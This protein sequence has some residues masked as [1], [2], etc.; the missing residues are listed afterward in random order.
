MVEEVKDSKMEWKALLEL[1]QDWMSEEVRQ[2]LNQSGQT[3]LVF[4]D[5][6]LEVHVCGDYKIGCSL[7]K[8]VC[9]K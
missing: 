1:T 6:V 3:L 4:G 5:C 9:L 8:S 7:F 2:V